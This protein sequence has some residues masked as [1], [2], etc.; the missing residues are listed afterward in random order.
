[1]PVDKYRG[2]SLQRELVDKIEEYVKTHPATGYKSTADFVT[3]S[4]RKRCEELNI[5]LPSPAEPPTLEHYNLNQDHVTIIDRAKKIFA[6]V[7]FRNSHVVCEA[8]QSE[9]CEHI[10]Y[11]L[12]L[13][14]VQKTLREKGWKIE[15]GKIIKNPH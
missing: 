1:M 15:E 10:V 14:K 3:D 8:C 5:I 11:A 9:N 12:T 13:S 2:I 7:Y 4:L 6:D